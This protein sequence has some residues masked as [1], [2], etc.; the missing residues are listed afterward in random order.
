MSYPLPVCRVK[1]SHDVRLPARAGRGRGARSAGIKGLLFE[2]RV[3]DTRHERAGVRSVRI[4]SGELE[5]LDGSRRDHDRRGPG[6]H[7]RRISLEASPQ[8]FCAP[9]EIH[10]EIEVICAVLR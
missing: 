8:L 6:F 2:V 1:P 4:G 7:S 10:C 5:G 9:A 3:P